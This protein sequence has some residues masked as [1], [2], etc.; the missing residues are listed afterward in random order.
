MTLAAAVG[1]PDEHVV[2]GRDAVAVVDVLQVV[3]VEQQQRRTALPLR[4]ASCACSRELFEERRARQGQRQRVVRRRESGSGK[5]RFGHRSVGLE[6]S[7][8]RGAACRV[9]PRAGVNALAEARAP[10]LHKLARA[11]T[12]NCFAPI[13]PHGEPAEQHAE[14][15][16]AGRPRCATNDGVSG[17]SLI[18]VVISRCWLKL[19]IHMS[20]ASGSMFSSVA[21]ASGSVGTSSTNVR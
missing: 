18:S 9:A 21:N 19:G 3:D 11:L 20:L 15:E 5:R 13:E 6:R 4:C 2:A 8:E 1:E 16:A 10:R 12:E 7:G 14:R 17:W